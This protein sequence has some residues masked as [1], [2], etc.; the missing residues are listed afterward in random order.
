MHRTYK[1]ATEKKRRLFKKGRKT[2]QTKTVPS[3]IRMS[4][5]TGCTGP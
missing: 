4:Q 1:K 5:L 2:K 3:E